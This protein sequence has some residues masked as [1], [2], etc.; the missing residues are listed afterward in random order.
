MLQLIRLRKNDDVSVCLH[1]KTNKAMIDMGLIV[2]GLQTTALLTA[3]GLHRDF[4]KRENKKLI[5][6]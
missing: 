2:Y 3:I 4:Q 5:K 1:Y 6:D